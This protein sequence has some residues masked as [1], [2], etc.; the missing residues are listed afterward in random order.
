MRVR[1]DRSVKLKE[2]VV[3]KERRKGKSLK[4]KMR[5]LC[6]QGEERTALYFS[7]TAKTENAQEPTRGKERPVLKSCSNNGNDRPKKIEFIP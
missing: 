1:D 7:Q 2:G 4:M 6:S 3:G 5:S